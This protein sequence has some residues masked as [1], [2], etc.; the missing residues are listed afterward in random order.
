MTLTG[1]IV[2][3][4]SVGGTTAFFF[5]CICRVLRPPG[6]TGKIHGVLDTELEIE[7]KERKRRLEGQGN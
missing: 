5:W 7:E 1:W 4:L 6:S 3:L 2:M